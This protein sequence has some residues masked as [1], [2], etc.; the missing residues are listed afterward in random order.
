MLTTQ[1][2]QALVSHDVYGPMIRRVAHSEAYKSN[3][4]YGFQITDD[5]DVIQDLFLQLVRTD[6]GV[7]ALGKLECAESWLRHTA[8]FMAQNA[9][10]KRIGARKDANG[11]RIGRLDILDVGMFLAA[12]E[13]APLHFIAPPP[14]HPEDV[15]A[16]DTFARMLEGTQ[17]VILGII[18]KVEHPQQQEALVGYYL[19]GEQQ[20][21][22]RD[23]QRLYRGH[24]KL[25][26]EDIASLQ[27][28][29]VYNFPDTKRQ[30]ASQAA[31]EA[32]LAV[33]E[34]G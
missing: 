23:K 26:P 2:Q 20:Q 19:R 6:M 9:I 3:G 29:R 10:D 15:A 32:L 11:K 28:W 17:K 8:R 24:K 31:P 4:I 22:S 33:A 18:R 25:A 27:A 16:E 7:D 13:A 5:D 14:P 34:K 30:P 12:Y 1:D 21:N